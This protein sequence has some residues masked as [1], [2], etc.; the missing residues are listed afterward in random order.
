MR[1]LSLD[2]LLPQTGKMRLIHHV[3]KITDDFVQCDMQVNEDNIFYDADI[4]G[5]YTWVGIELMAQAVALFAS[6]HGAG[7]TPKTGLLLSARQFLNKNKLFS[8]GDK[9]IIEASKVYMEG[10]VAVF[11]GKIFCR[12]ECVVSAKLNAYQ[13]SE[14]QLKEILKGNKKNEAGINNWRK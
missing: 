9:L 4:D 1:D 12:Y 10:S 5:I 7:N 11:N 8:L 14:S 13:P 3:I 2:N 6:Y